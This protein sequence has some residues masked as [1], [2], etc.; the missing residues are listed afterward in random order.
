MTT[1]EKL[2]DRFAQS[3]LIEQSLDQSSEE[4]VILVDHQ[5]Q[6][7][8]VAEKLQAHQDGLLHRAF[9]I[10]ILN[11]QGKLLLQKRARHKYHSGGLWTN[12]CCS[13]PRPHE[14]ILE[15]AHRRLQEEM[16]LECELTEIFSF[17]YRAELDQG[18]TEYEFDHV[19]LGYGD[20]E[21]ILN[22]DEAEDWCWID[23]SM[24]QKDIA[25]NPQ[26]YTYWLRDCCDRFI[27][28]LALRVHP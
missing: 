2:P 12:T 28:Q 22:P 5:D 21:P 14:N 3:Q 20:R 13:H 16:G 26:N 8:G 27:D 17:V 19:L 4:Q 24:L 6:Q 11:S 9:S 1:I 18:L 10:F 7:I 25:A 23:L 15:A